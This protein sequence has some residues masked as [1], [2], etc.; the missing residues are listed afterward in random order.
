[1]KA[2]VRALAAAAVLTA[3]GM[4]MAAEDPESKTATSAAVVPGSAKSNTT[5]ACRTLI[6]GMAGEWEGTIQTRNGEGMSSSSVVSATLRLEEGGKRLAMYYEGFAFGKPVDGAMLLSASAASPEAALSRDG[7]TLN[8]TG[9]LNGASMSFSFQ[10][11]STSKKVVRY[12]QSVSL[13][14]PNHFVAEL[15]AVDTEGHK[16][17]AFRLDMT[18][19]EGDQK[20]AAAESFSQSKTL[21]ASARNAVRGGEAVQ[22]AGVP[23]E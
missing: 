12:E 21:L 10:P 18:R 1:M 20:S 2:G 4:S 13:S 16:S 7:T 5:T 3:A 6:K 11:A 9:A 15:N 19:L 22:Q 8:G 17:L 23:T 14:E